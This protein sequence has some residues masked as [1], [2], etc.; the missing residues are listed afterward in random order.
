MTIFDRRG[1]EENLR[2]TYIGKTARRP[3]ASVEVGQQG[4][5]WEIEDDPDQECQLIVRELAQQARV[6]LGLMAFFHTRALDGPSIWCAK[7]LARRPTPVCW[8]D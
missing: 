2:Y 3:A 4:P 5:R 1:A 8:V 6:E 7:Y